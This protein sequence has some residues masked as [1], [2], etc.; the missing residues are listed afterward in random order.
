MRSN[1]VLW[2]IR[3]GGGSFGLDFFQQLKSSES[4]LEFLKGCWLDCSS[5]FNIKMA[6]QSRSEPILVSYLFRVQ[7]VPLLVF[8]SRSAKYLSYRDCSSN[9]SFFFTLRRESQMDNRFLGLFF[10]RASA[11]TTQHTDLASAENASST[12]AWLVAGKQ[13]STVKRVLSRYNWLVTHFPFQATTHTSRKWI[14]EN[15][16]RTHTLRYY[17]LYI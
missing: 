14:S 4:I 11:T 12:L 8:L 16:L 17:D 6:M 2:K 1:H 3:F 10:F 5:Y 7:H 15:L 13:S 9:N